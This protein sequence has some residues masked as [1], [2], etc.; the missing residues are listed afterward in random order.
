MALRRLIR[1]ILEK[2]STVI[3]TGTDGRIHELFYGPGGTNWQTNDL[4]LAAGA[5][6][7]TSGSPSVYIHGAGDS[8]SNQAA[9]NRIAI[10]HLG[11]LVVYVN[12]GTNVEY[13]TATN[14]WVVRQRNFAFSN[15]VDNFVSLGSNTGGGELE[16]EMGHYFHLPHTFGPQPKTEAEAKELIR[17]YVDDQGHSASDG[18]K[19]FDADAALIGDT[20]PDPG[21]DLWVAMKGDQCS[22]SNTIQ[23]TVQLKSSIQI[24]T[25]QP[26]RQNLMG[27]FKKDCKQ[28]Q[29]LMFLTNNQIARMQSALKTGNRQHLK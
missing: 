29:G 8:Y 10:Q 4:S 6:P 27:Y 9:R 20:P 13:D 12:Y 14:Q 16:H 5:L 11:K 2:I 18:A 15:S 19:V 28:F 24:Y 23:L 17:V 26:M 22:I 3:Y 21:P 25:L 1:G 7:N